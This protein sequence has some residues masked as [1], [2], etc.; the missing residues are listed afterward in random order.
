VLE[1]PRSVRLAAWGTA[2][3]GGQ[4]VVDDAVRA[5]TED[6]EPH[7]VRGDDPLALPPGSGLGDVLGRLR[8]LG[9]PGLRVLLPAPGDVLGLPGPPPFNE[10]AVGAGECVLTEPVTHGWAAAFASP[11]G[12]VP[13]VSTFGSAW[14]PGAQVEWSLHTV[15]RARTTVVGSL[16]EA[17]RELRQALITATETLSRLDVAR[18]RDDAA[19]RVAAARDGA[20][21]RTALPPSAPPRTARVLAMAARVRAIVAL[22]AADDGA[23]ISGYEAQQRADALRRLD[24]V[25]RR[26]LAAAVNGML[27]PQP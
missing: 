5:V 8:D 9:V 22:A 2:V 12:L 18:W 25:S 26:A 7:A 11:L 27:E 16:A 15:N 14:E 3:L 4:V 6:D 21:P 24:G 19:D 13:E 17:E 23:A 20:L 1:L 10:C